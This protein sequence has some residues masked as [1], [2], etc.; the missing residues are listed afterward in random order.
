[1]MPSLRGEET[2][3]GRGPVTRLRSESEEVARG[4]PGAQALQLQT[5]FFS[6]CF[7]CMMCEGPPE[8]FHLLL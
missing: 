3:A 2:E 1:M 5:A 4:S 6:P 7:T 8:V